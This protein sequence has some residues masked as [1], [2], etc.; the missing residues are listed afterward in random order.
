MTALFLIM[1]GVWTLIMLFTAVHMA[2]AETREDE[3]DYI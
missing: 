3:E 1:A 2:L